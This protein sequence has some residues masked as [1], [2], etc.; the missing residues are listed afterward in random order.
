MFLGINFVNSPVEVAMPRDNGVT[1]DDLI[2]VTAPDRMPPYSNNTVAF[3]INTLQGLVL[4][5]QPQVQQPWQG[6]PNCLEKF[7][8]TL[9][10]FV[11][12]DDSKDI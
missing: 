1:S 11:A 4:E 10:L 3:I 8:R 5:W 2:S 12:P 9:G 6:P 7:Q